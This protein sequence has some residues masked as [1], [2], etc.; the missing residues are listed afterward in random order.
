MPRF[1]PGELKVMR[2]LWEHGEMKPGELQKRFPEPIK[3]PA[4]RSYLTTLVEKGHVTR[5]LVGKAY[6]YKPATRPR[7]AFRSM[8]GEL[9]DVYCGGSVQDL[10]MNIIRSEKLS[11]DELL[12]LK[13]LADSGDP[14]S[15]PLNKRSRK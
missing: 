5:R 2:L 1:T 13:R 10:V 8:L 7:S 6:Y 4:L 9:V 14:T 11:E 3:N 12:S 15:K